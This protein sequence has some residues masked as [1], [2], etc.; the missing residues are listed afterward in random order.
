MPIDL[1][2]GFIRVPVPDALASVSL[3]E[4]GPPD[5]DAPY[6]VKRLLMPGDVALCVGPPASG[7]TTIVPD[8]AWRIA[9][10]L[11]FLG[12][13]TCATAVL[14]CP[15]E[16]HDGLRRRFA[17][18]AIA[19]DMPRPPI[20][21][22]TRSVNLV[23][24]GGAAIA[25]VADEH[26]CGL[27]IIDTLNAACPGLDENSPS[28]MG[29]AVAALRAIASPTPAV[30]ALHHTPRAGQHPRGHSALEAAADLILSVIPPE[31]GRGLRM[32]KVTKCRHG[33]AGEHWPFIIK[34][35][36]LGIDAD[37]EEVAGLVPQ[38]EEPAAR[39]DR[40]VRLRPN[41]R[42]A[43]RLL[44]DLLAEEGRPLPASWQMAPALRAVLLQRWR[45]HCRERGLTADPDHFR[46]VFSRV[47]TSLRDV[48]RIACRE[49]QGE[50]LVWACRREEDE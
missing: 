36:P 19:H 29:R 27:V 20:R 23:E 21:L 46:K 35:V 10:G 50:T 32:L 5:L 22:A 45:A 37:G 40:S 1:P 25:S 6:L 8:W 30:V 28:E 44:H 49:H 14:Y 2:P 41:A 38:W 9:A 43:L 16:D 24:D 39:A 12:R 47:F 18:L 42:T 13:R 31:D 17:A 48:R 7:K 11:P 26:G 33:P 34:P 4:L 3:G 15:L